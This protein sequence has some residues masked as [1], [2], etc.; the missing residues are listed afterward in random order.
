VRRLARSATSLTAVDVASEVD[1]G[2]TEGGGARNASADRSLRR[3]ADGRE[4]HIVKH[5]H[6][7]PALEAELAE[8][9]WQASARLAPR[10]WFISG[11]ARPTAP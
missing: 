7:P 1:S 8:L 5:F 10:G 6:E 2:P 4:F 9:G 3:L 11:E